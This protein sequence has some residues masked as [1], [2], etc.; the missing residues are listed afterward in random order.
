MKTFNLIA[1]ATA[2]AL[3]ALAAYSATGPAPLHGLVI[4]TAQTENLDLVELSERERGTDIAEL[5]ER[6]RETDIAELSE[7][8]RKPG[9]A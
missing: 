9:I 8:E 2:A 5:S 6:E 4:K 7:E 3:P 1:V